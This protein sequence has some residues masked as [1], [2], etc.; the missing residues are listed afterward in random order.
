MLRGGHPNSLGR[1]QEVVDLVLHDQ[2]RLEALFNTLADPDAVVR[3]RAGDALEKVCRVQPRRFHS[4]VERLLGEVGQ[5]VQPSVQ[6]HV[7]QMLDH[8]RADLTPQQGARATALLRHNLSTSP[9]WIVR[10]TTMDVLTAWAAS[11]GDLADWLAPQL[12]R[13]SRD[14]RRAVATRAVK[15]LATVRGYLGRE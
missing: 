8:L 5:I 6:W 13:L 11:D 7:A 15:R 1:T 9:D 10:N 2:T 14:P 4:Y 3:M 12:E